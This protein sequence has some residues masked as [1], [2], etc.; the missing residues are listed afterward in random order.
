MS[1]IRQISIKKLFGIFNH[2]IALH[3]DRRVTIIHSPNAFGKTAI[4]KLL[5]ELFTRGATLELLLLMSVT[6]ISKIRGTCRRHERSKRSFPHREAQRTCEVRQR[7]RS[8]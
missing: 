6:S 4:C 3:M 2:E 8:G 7:P 5:K 1:I